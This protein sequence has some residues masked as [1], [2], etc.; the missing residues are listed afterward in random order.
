MSARA[1]GRA[2]GE[3]GGAEPH[4]RIRLREIQ[5][6][7]QMLTGRTQHQMAASLGITQAGVSKIVRRIEER[8]LADVAYKVERQRARQTLQLSFLYAEAMG[9][10]RASQQDAIRRRQ[11]QSGEI[12]TGANVAELVT[13]NQHGDPR[14]LE[15]ARKTLADLRIVWGVD[16]PD[17]IE[18]VTR[19]AAM[20]DAALDAELAQQM[21]LLRL[22][23]GDEAS[24]ET[25][26]VQTSASAPHEGGEP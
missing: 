23:A 5:V 22:E 9:G 7:E 20:T 21:R 17:R 14:Y 2:R 15:V 4:R 3:R 1:R 25:A 24:T 16:A 26:A 19:Y 18:T 10:W 8:L 11:R 12:G 13:E 6:L